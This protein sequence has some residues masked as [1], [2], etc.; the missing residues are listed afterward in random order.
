MLHLRPLLSE[1]DLSSS[2]LEPFFDEMLT[3]LE[4]VFG[5]IH[6]VPEEYKCS[7]SAL[8]EVI[9]QSVEG[10]ENDNFLSVSV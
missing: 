6:V 10:I 8:V 5:A 4:A 2:S 9:G 1:A 7:T 3:W